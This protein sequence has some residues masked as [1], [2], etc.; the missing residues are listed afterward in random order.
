MKYI[1]LGSNCSVAYQLKKKNLKNDC[2]PFDW[3]KISILQLIEVLNNNFE[4]YSNSIIIKKISQ[5]H[6]SIISNY[7]LI[8][9]NKYN[10]QFAHEIDN[11]SKLS[12][13]I[14]KINTRIKNFTSISL[15]DKIT[16]IRIE[17]K[18]I[19]LIYREYIIKLAELLNKYSSNYILKLI[20]N[21][22]IE[23]TNLPLNIQIYKFN[24]FDSNWQMNSINWNYIFD[25]NLI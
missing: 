10:I 2:Y 22:N 12:I 7:S 24:E 21:T 4:N 17:L 20:I 23:F 14:N 6:S 9:K 1:S 25:L 13:F 18:P 11:E 8:L 16:F 15:I 3:C 19:K 5:K